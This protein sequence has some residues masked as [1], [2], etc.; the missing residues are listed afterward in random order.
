MAPKLTRGRDAGAV[1]RD[2][3]ADDGGARSRDRERGRRSR[4]S[5]LIYQFLLECIFIFAT[6]RITVGAGQAS[7]AP[8]ARE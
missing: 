1:S 8:P 5:I 6:R 7:D 3:A 2:A 4:E